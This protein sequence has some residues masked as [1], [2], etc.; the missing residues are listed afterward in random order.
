[1]I[2]NY[3][4]VAEYKR[5]YLDK[6]KDQKE[7]IIAESS[8]GDGVEMDIYLP[9]KDRFE[10]FR[11]VYNNTEAIKLIYMNPAAEYIDTTYYKECQKVK[12]VNLYNLLSAATNLMARH[13]SATYFDKQFSKLNKKEFE[14]ITVD[15]FDPEVVNDYCEHGCCEQTIRNVYKL[16]KYSYGTYHGRACWKSEVDSY[17]AK[18]VFERL[19]SHLSDTTYVHTEEFTAALVMFAKYKGIFDTLKLEKDGPNYSMILPDF[20]EVLNA[21][22]G[23]I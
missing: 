20:Y 13:E 17:A 1:M 12:E 22:S 8:Y 16:I 10:P 9:Y 14:T 15:N 2:H 5:Q 23:R 3:S 11:V 7:P 19:L 4:I 6:F 21:N 18:H